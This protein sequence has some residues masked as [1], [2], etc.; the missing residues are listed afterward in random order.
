[1]GTTL[2]ARSRWLPRFRQQPQM[3]DPLLN[4]FKQLS[5][6]KKRLSTLPTPHKFPPPIGYDQLSLEVHEGFDHV[7]HGDR[8][9]GSTD[10]VSL[11]SNNGEHNPSSH[12]IRLITVLLLSSDL[13]D[14]PQHKE[15]KGPDEQEDGELI[16]TP[17]LAPGEAK[18]LAFALEISKGF[19][20]RMLSALDPFR[21]D[22]CGVAVD[23][24]LQLVLARRWPG[25]TR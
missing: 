19:L 14:Q 24:N 5:G 6:N 9:G 13:A 20:N 10:H 17:G 2:F 8:L 4:G 16:R 11:D 3:I 1:M 21:E 25:R 12:R 23:Y 22:I 15:G 7:T 18:A